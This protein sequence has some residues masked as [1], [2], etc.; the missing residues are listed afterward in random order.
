[1]A[2]LNPVGGEVVMS[3]VIK[4]VRITCSIDPMEV[5]T[6]HVRFFR[7]QSFDLSLVQISHQRQMIE[8]REVN[9]A[10]L[11]AGL[12]KFSPGLEN[13]RVALKFALMIGRSQTGIID[14]NLLLV[15]DGIEFLLGSPISEQ[16]AFFGHAFAPV[17]EHF[18]HGRRRLM[19]Q[20]Q[21]QN[22][23]HLFF[24]SPLFYHC[25]ALPDTLSRAGR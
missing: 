5:E 24:K 8:F 14:E 6:E 22:G 16:N 9:V 13:S 4:K 20:H 21:I 15:R 25:L 3:K 1:M 7:S 10:E 19:R 2:D 18:C 23:F 11:W 17:A 12:E